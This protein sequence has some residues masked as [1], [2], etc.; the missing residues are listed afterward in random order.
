MYE[1]I[2]IAN[3]TYYVNCPAKIGIYRNDDNSVYLID[4]GNDKDAGRKVRKIVEAEGWSV[5]AILN[6]HAHADHTGG[7]KFLQQ[8][9]GCKIFAPGIDG[10]ITRH[11]ILEPALL[12][13]GLPAK[14]LRHKFLMAQESECEDVTSPDFPTKIE[15]I[16]LRGHYFDMV[17][18]RTPDNVVFL[19]DC[20]S[21]PVTLEKYQIGYIY[22]IQAYLDTLDFIETLSAD[23]FVPSHAEPCTDIHELAELNRRKT[24]EIAGLILELCAEPINFEALLQLIFAHYELTMTFE[25][26]ALVGSTVRSYLSWLLD[27]GKMA[28]EIDNNLLLWKTVR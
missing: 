3:N 19:A 7:N 1:L 9:T 26:Y 2:K 6:T 11:P 18:Y 14:P 4:S 13:G 16:P 12:Y 22:D 25:Q 27:S 24:L 17:G 23:L 21:S 20:V 8:N 28:T 5:K 15:V 10:D